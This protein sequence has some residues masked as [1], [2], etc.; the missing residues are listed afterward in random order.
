MI[1]FTYFC[2]ISFTFFFYLISFFYLRFSYE[3]LWR[4]KLQTYVEFPIEDL[5]LR[6]S[7]SNESNYSLYGVVNHYGT[8]EGGHYTAFS[9]S[10]NTKNQW[11][12]FDD[13][14]ITQISTADVKT[15][16]AYVLFYRNT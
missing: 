3:G 10:K 14:E 9:R 12:R 7:N 15:Q 6:S 13:Q 1:C 16:A 4:Q 8:L 2:L 11:H 5:A